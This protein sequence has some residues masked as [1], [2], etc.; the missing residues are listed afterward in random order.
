[1]DNLPNDIIFNICRF[2][3]YPESKAF[4]NISLPID[5]MILN[6]EFHKFY[7]GYSEI[8]EDD[9]CRGCGFERG[10]DKD[11]KTIVK[12]L[13]FAGLC[14][15]CYY[16]DYKDYFI[17]NDIRVQVKCINSKRFKRSKCNCEANYFFYTNFQNKR[18]KEYK[19]LKETI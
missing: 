13:G 19:R 14:M 2:L 7:V 18:L 16:S 12:D 3:P 6:S 15:K 9:F 8:E 17:C 10:Q 5:K 11:N 1:M 4:K